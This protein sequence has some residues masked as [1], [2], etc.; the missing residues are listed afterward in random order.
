MR[1][2]SSFKVRLLLIILG[3][4]VTSQ[5]VTGL[6]VGHRT[7]S[8]GQRQAEH[9]L[10]S[11]ARIFERL[12]SDRER[13]LA[14][15]VSIL[16]ADFALRRALATG[17]RTTLES[18]LENHGGRVGAGVS[19]F[20][21][22]EREIQALA[23]LAV[24][25]DADLASF[26][27]LVDRA[28]ED[29]RSTG[30][31]FVGT[32]PHQIVLV[33]VRS[34]RT[35]GW[36]GMGFP[37]DAAL[38]HSLRDL[39]DL[40]V[41]FW[42]RAVQGDRVEVASTL[43]TADKAAFEANLAKLGTRDTLAE[44]ERSSGYES[45]WL[46]RSFARGLDE[47]LTFGVVLQTS[48]DEA[49]AP[50]VAQ[51][52]Q[53]TT[54]FAFSLALALAATLAV[55]GRITRPVSA[56]A[57]AA[58]AISDGDLDAPIDV[59]D[60]G[61][62]LAELA[63]TFRVMQSA[64]AEREAA[65]LHESTHDRLTGLPNRYAVEEQISQRLKSQQPFAI[66]L[67]DIVRLKDVNQTLGSGIGD[68]SLVGLAKRFQAIESMD[69]IGRFGG[70]E[71]IAVFEGAEEPEELEGLAIQ[72]IDILGVRQ[73]L[74]EIQVALDLVA[75]AVFAPK[76]GATTDVLLRRVEIALASAKSTDQNVG[77]FQAGVEEANQRRVGIAIE[78]E[79]AL[80]SGA[81]E[82]HYQPKIDIRSGRAV[83]AEALIRW[84]HREMGRMNPEEFIGIA[85]QT[86]FV[87]QI[88][89]W[90][91]EEASAQIGIWTKRNMDLCVSINLSAHDAGL[92]D[93]PERIREALMAN[94][95]PPERLKV[96]VTESAVMEKPEQ[97]VKILEEIRALGVGVSIDDFGTGHSSLAQV[98][99]LPA[100]ELKIDQCFVRTLRE[101]T[102]DEVIVRT[103]IDLAHS[104][105][106]TVVAEGVED[107]ISWDILAKNGCDVAQGYWM[108]RPMPADDFAV[109][110]D[111]F[112]KDGL[113]EVE[114]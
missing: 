60:T 67:F 38:A 58:N 109:W 93:L 5:V 72:A 102:P 85:E 36:I 28:Q 79:R 86:G 18:A 35:I 34:P 46:T 17:D 29:G 61:D 111:R 59:A 4:V 10:D 50:M 14:S 51:L 108:G 44:V 64:L 70:D 97:A 100:D 75:G 82:L 104:L 47:D 20:V 74:G 95:A 15:N 90:V 37:L 33:P 48:Y 43:P 1:H 88:S 22:L 30:I 81:F 49:M 16:A 94:E 45:G 24:Q 42:S 31:G 7:R 107:R 91:I 41:S 83:G 56:L 54:F 52:K 27:K 39:T 78:L 71:F 103:T 65:I 69:W 112:E 23:P 98:K 21:N 25:F 114:G 96:E 73:D 92:P 106:L 87:Q 101:G 57:A 84:T 89:Q 8:E 80:A 76:D 66:V 55:A 105:G 11:G 77:F 26:Q 3:L 110:L 19:F 9:A 68:R 6:V 99:R 113:S 13:Q 62:E 2:R 40:Q 53:L 63:H 12:L 32:R